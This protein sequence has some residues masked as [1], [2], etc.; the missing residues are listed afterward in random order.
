MTETPGFRV[1]ISYSH[2]DEEDFAE[3]LKHLSMLKRHGVLSV[4]H[5]RCIRAGDAFDNV[6]ADELEAADIIL[7]LVSVNFLDSDYC[8]EIE[9]TRA[10]ERHGAGDAIVIPIIIKHCDDW[11]SAPFGKLNAAPPGDKPIEDFSSKDKGYTQ[12]TKMIREAATALR[13]KRE[14]APKLQVNEPAS[15]AAGW[16]VPFEKNINFTGR[17]E[18][19][20]RL[21]LALT[22][23]ERAALTALSGLG[24]IGKTQTA[25]EYAYRHRAY[26]RLIWWL[27]AEE[28]A[29]LAADFSALAGPLGLDV[30]GDQG[31][32]IEA[33]R[34]RLDREDGW[35]LIF[36]NAEEAGDLR[37]YLP[38]QRRGRV[39][40]TSRNPNW[41]GVA[42]PLPVAVMSE[43]EAVALLLRYRDEDEKSDAKE[44]AEALGY[45]PLA[46]AQARAYSEHV[47]CTLGAYLDLLRRREAELLAQPHTPGDYGLPV[48]AAWDL[49]FETIQDT[50]GAADLLNLLSYLAPEAF[51]KDLLTEHADKLQDDLAAIALDP[52][53]LDAAIAALR[54]ASLMEAAGDTLTTHRLVQAITRSRCRAADAE[55]GVVEQAIKLVDAPLH[56]E[57]WD[58][59]QWP[60]YARLLAHATTIADHAE[61]HEVAP[62]T[63]GRILNQIALYHFSQAAYDEALPLCKR[64]I[65]IT[66]KALGPDHPDL[67]ISLNTLATLLRHMGHYEEALP[68]IKHAIEI[69]EKALGPD[70]PNLAVWLNNLANLHRDQGRYDEA[71]PLFERAMAITEK[72]LG[73]EH[74]NLAKWLNNLANLHRDQGHYDEALPLYQRA[75]EI[76]EEALGPDHPDLAIWLNNL[77]K[78]HH[79]QGSYDEALPLYK[80]SLAILEV[81]LPADHPHIEQ[82]RKN[83]KACLRDAGKSD[84]DT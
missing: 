18:L 52:F 14:A 46:L 77:A 71:L 61:Q 24:G 39:I 23:N 48:A 68:L 13:V 28:T 47:G 7:L 19:L 3:L 43:E 15:G 16:N 67:A 1:F 10:M 69:G 63:T 5:D 35:L 50:P 11:Q 81:K 44:L 66:E 27:R 58:I 55:L 49:A 75:I 56:E 21:H 54:R 65:E 6:I 62:E 31:K 51:P 82:V 64:D 2:G 29:T 57:A 40:I 4:W 42:H 53:K 73:P 70:H 34:E 45:L 12:V 60:V 74:P 33:V 20:E 41:G 8:Y 22:A 37:P 59:R 25:I 80:R 72:T 79:D 38:L 32:T 76:G 26:Y 83:Y 36:D 17:V 84:P 9:M 78:L 30:S